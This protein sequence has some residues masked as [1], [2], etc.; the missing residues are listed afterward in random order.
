MLNMALRTAV[1]AVQDA[2][3]EDQT[4]TIAEENPAR[5]YGLDV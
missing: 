2:V 4:R 1:A 3:G 5:V